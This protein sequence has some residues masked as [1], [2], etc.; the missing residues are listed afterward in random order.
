MGMFSRLMSQAGTNTAVDPYHEMAG[1]YNV[2]HNPS[3]P[4]TY[5]S[6]V[7]QMIFTICRWSYIWPILNITISHHQSMAIKSKCS[8]YSYPTIDAYSRSILAKDRLEQRA[9]HFLPKPHF[10]WLLQV[11]SAD[12]VCHTPYWYFSCLLLSKLSRSMLS[13]RRAFPFHSRECSSE[14]L[15]ALSTCSGCAR[16]I[17]TPTSFD[18]LHLEVLCCLLITVDTIP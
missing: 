18:R 4:E 3:A 1:N 17:R 7:S 5:E 15:G 16:H 8:G 11:K 2:A 13:Q 12:G 14:D 10:F 9:A 6:R